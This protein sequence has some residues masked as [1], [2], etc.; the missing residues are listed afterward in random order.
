LGRSRQ[1]HTH[2]PES[3]NRKTKSAPVQ[4]HANFILSS[5]KAIWLQPFESAFLRW[6][7]NRAINLGT[8][9]RKSGAWD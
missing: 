3:Q 5:L 1:S 6:W 4:L 8:T 2:H 7:L 9:L